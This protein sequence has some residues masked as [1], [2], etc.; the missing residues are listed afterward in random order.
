M[1]CTETILQR[2]FYLKVVS[3]QM[4]IK[5]KMKLASDVKICRTIKNLILNIRLILVIRLILIITL[6]NCKSS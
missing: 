1:K 4:G 5:P 6:E 2:F 3:L